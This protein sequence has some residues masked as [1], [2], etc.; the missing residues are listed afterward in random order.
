MNLQSVNRVMER[1]FDFRGRARRSEFFYVWLANLL[2]AI[3]LS[4]PMVCFIW[5]LGVY[6]QNFTFAD[7]LTE[8]L[9]SPL[10]VLAYIVWSLLATV[11]GWAGVVAQIF[12]SVRRLNDLGLSRWWWLVY[13]VPVVNFFFFVFLLF[14][15]GKPEAA[16]G[17]K[18]GE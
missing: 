3:L 18:T 11:G 9:L 10:N 8:A 4:I 5:W 1:V 13:F 14:M 12:T 17:E 15:P 6:G 16:G 2:Y 7:E